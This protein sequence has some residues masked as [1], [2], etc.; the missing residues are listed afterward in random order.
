MRKVLVKF[1]RYLGTYCVLNVPRRRISVWNLAP[2]LA[3]LPLVAYFYAV[4]AIYTERMESFE[5]RLAERDL[6]TLRERLEKAVG[7]D[8]LIC[9]DY[10][11][12]N[13]SYEQVLRG[14]PK[15]IEDNL[16]NG[17]AADN[18]GYEIVLFQSANG[19]VVFQKGFTPQIAR[20]IQNYRLLEKCL[21]G[22]EPAGLAMLNNKLYICSARSIVKSNGTG[23]PRGM[24]FTARLVDEDVLEDLSP[25][26][27]GRLVAHAR[28][29]QSVGVHWLGGKP[30][31]PPSLARVLSTAYIPSSRIVEKSLDGSL[32]YGCLPVNDLR[33]NPVGAMIHVVSRAALIEN[34]RMVQ[35]TSLI[36]MIMFAFTGLVGVAYMRNRT[37]ALRIHRDELT[38]L[39]NHGY[40]Q[41]FLKKQIQIS[42]RYSKPLSVIML[43]VDHFKFINDAYC[44]SAGD[45]VLKS[46]AAIINETVRGTDLVARYGGEE[47]VV[48]CPETSL[49]QAAAVAE[50]IRATIESRSITL[51][52]TRTKE[53]L[54]AIELHVTISGGVATYPDDGTHHS[55]LL[56]AADAALR[57]AKRMRNRVVVFA[58]ITPA[59]KP[60]RVSVIDAFLRDSSISAIR[61]LIAAIEAR[62]PNTI[63]HS[64]KT[65]EYAVAIGREMGFSTYDLSLI[66][67]AALL[68][69]VGMIAVPSHILIKETALTEEE[70]E[71]IKRHP[72][73]GA[74]ILAQSPQLANVAN[75]I[76]YHHENWDGSGYPKGLKGEEIPIMARVIN[77]AGALDSMTSPR[78]YRDCKTLVEAKQE[79]MAQ[80]G[81]QFDPEVVRAACRVIDALLRQQEAVQSAA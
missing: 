7:R 50:R 49:A 75:I 26:T 77:V 18:F 45:M 25:G 32:L 31:L 52:P 12:W 63:R 2:L 33:G 71:A 8:S 37:L 20:G 43:D 6:D 42:D 54:G 79:I 29:G 40:L 47:F 61:P 69:D 60:K 53:H 65:A 39:Y 74:A 4:Q 30:N 72:E 17:I 22:Q 19:K 27:T 14:D 76:L 81:K 46:V 80:S 66:F 21:A 24:F 41:E 23:R 68:H 11:H 64:E 62:D 48:V 36:L 59:A 58:D 28:N 1:L 51:K 56:E 73:V 57:E 15:W 35:Q 13:D 16:I 9:R 70:M 78:S 10:A 3:V 34:L 67:K 44:H 55:E 38:G 5:R